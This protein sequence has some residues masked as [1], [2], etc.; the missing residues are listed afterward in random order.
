MVKGS[1]AIRCH[2]PRLL[3]GKVLPVGE[4]S[5]SDRGGAA[6]GEEAVPERGLRDCIKLFERS[7]Y[8]I[9]ITLM[10]LQSMLTVS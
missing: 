6:S 5:R 2:S 9:F 8:Q 1:R 3:L 7:E 10:L 4:T